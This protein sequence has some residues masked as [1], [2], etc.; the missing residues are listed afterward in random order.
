MTAQRPLAQD[1]RADRPPA[2]DVPAPAPLPV[3]RRRV[4]PSIAPA[5]LSEESVA[6]EEDPGA[7]LDTP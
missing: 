2:A 3:P 5:D 1:E 6:G 4:D 7:A